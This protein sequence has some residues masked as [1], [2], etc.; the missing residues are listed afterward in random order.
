MCL[1]LKARRAL[2]AS[3]LALRAFISWFSLKTPVARAHVAWRRGTW[4]RAAWGR[5]RSRW[6]KSEG[7][8]LR[9]GR[10]AH[11]VQAV[12]PS[13]KVDLP[14]LLFS[15]SSQVSAP[16]PALEGPVVPWGY[17][18]RFCSSWQAP[19]AVESS[20]ST[21]RTGA[22]VPQGVP[23]RAVLREPPVTRE[24]VVLLEAGEP[25]VLR[26]LRG[27]QAP[28]VQGGMR[29][30]PPSARFLALIAPRSRSLR[31]SVSGLI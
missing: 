16:P 15:P 25:A 24:P 3:G 13:P 23:E 6:R 31:G 10:V 18:L 11:K 30:G 19:L 28:V 4:A 21:P 20:S 27:T 8:S 12:S 1:Q 29:Q 22:P 7:S 14:C 9:S 5:R 26:G 2:L 17:S